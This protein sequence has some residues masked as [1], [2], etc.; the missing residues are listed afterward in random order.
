MKSFSLSVLAVLLSA[1]S[2]YAQNVFPTTAGTSAGIYTTAPTHSLTLGNGATGVAAYNTSDQ[3]TNYERM[4]AG[5]NSNAYQI[6]TYSGGT[7]T[8]RSLQ[9]GV[10]TVSGASTLAS[11]RVFT[12][13]S[14]TTAT[15]GIF[16][17]SAATMGT[18]SIIT[19]RGTAAAA[20]GTQNWLSMQPSINQTGTAGYK[21]LLISPYE[22]GL[23]SAATNYLIDAGTNS[24]ANTA[25]THTSKFV[26]TSTGNVGIN[27]SYIPSGYQLAIN[28]SA[29]ATSVTVKLY[30]TWPD[31]VFKKDYTLPSLSDVKTYIDKNQHLPEIPS[32]QEI[33]K[34]GINLGEMNKLLLK[35]VEELTLYLIEK[36]KEVK[37]ERELNQKQQITLN[38]QTLSTQAQE[39]KIKQLAK[40]LEALAKKVATKE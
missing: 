5:W 39:E 21:V 22:Q 26:V 35:K 16:D 4:V 6:A 20:A 30:A 17:F 38:A 33:A 3:T 34:D 13:N 32:A 2:S 36:D 8:N 37:E 24:S 14:V 9:I 15:T 28:G 1:I 7:G 23:G 18:G 27:T 19:M 31:Y 11:G 40:Q 10:Q 25:G 29:I 12:I